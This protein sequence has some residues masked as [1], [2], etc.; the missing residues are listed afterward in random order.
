MWGSV[1]GVERSGEPGGL[2]EDRVGTAGALAWVLDGASSVMVTDAATDSLWVVDHL[3]R[4]L[5]ELADHPVPLDELVA[6][7]IAR[8]AARAEREWLATPMCPRP[9]RRGW[10]AGYWVASTDPEAAHHAVTA[11]VEDVDEIILAT[12]G[13]M[14]AVELF[15]LVSDLADLF[16]R[17]LAEVADGIRE[18]ELDDPDVRRFPRWRVHDD[19]CALRLRWSP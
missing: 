12:D 3:D 15:G 11:D 10:C 5:R 2:S 4:A 9:P 13:F 16:V 6:A 7:A 14:R 17:D 18:M 1:D 19:I 8:L